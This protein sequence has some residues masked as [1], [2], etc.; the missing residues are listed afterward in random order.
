MINSFLYNESPITTI[1]TPFP[2]KMPSFSNTQTL[3]LNTKHIPYE[4]LLHPAQ[5]L[6]FHT[7]LSFLRDAMLNMFVFHT[8]H[9]A[10]LLCK[11]TLV[12]QLRCRYPML[13]SCPTNSLLPNLSS[14]IPLCATA[15]PLAQV[16][17]IKS[18]CN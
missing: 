3:T 7:I 15:V 17:I 6:T 16:K 1:V 10:S 18:H 14:N 11:K 12:I 13:D 8:P 9:R 4:C 5:L 2:K